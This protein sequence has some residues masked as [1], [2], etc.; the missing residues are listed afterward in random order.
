MELVAWFNAAYPG[1]A[2]EE[3]AV[4]LWT[5]Q[6]E[7]LD[8]DTASHVAQRWIRTEVTPPTIAGFRQACRARKGFQT[9]YEQTQKELAALKP[10]PGEKR[11]LPAEVKEWMDTKG[12]KPLEIPTAE[13]VQPVNVMEALK[14]GA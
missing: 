8:A 11:E 14:G 3:L 10:A 5:D 12:W 1:L 13:E 9:E 2:L 7:D 4:A 6:I